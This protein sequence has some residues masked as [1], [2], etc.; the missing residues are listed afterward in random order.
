M[1][2]H[3]IDNIYALKNDPP[4]QLGRK[5]VYSSES[6]LTEAVEKFS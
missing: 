6:R 3:A 2:I 4:E 1:R 5:E